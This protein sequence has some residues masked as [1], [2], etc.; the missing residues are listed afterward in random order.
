MGLAGTELE[1]VGN[2]DLGTIEADILFLANA[3]GRA[4]GDV[5]YQQ[6]RLFI[7][8]VTKVTPPFDR[9][10]DFDESFAQQRK[11][12][13]GAVSGDIQ[14]AFQSFDRISIFTEPTDESL[15]QRFREVVRKGDVGATLAIMRNVTGRDIRA[16]RV[17][18]APDTGKHN[19]LRTRRGRVKR[20]PFPYWTFS[21]APIKA[22]IREKQELVGRAKAGWLSAASKLGV[23]LP[24][25]ISGRG[26]GGVTDYSERGD[27]PVIILTNRVPYISAQNAERRFVELALRE[28]EGAMQRQLQAKLDGLWSRTL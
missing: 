27:D 17:I 22:F 16:D 1:L 10:G 9:F 5:V 21:A 14:N 6:A 15:G 12:G 18:S 11:V 20:L 8:D 26:E 19:K 28:R 7:R 4:A 13:M 25:W 24:N 2:V 3:T 23:S